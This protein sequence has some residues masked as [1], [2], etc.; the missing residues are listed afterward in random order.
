M[1]HNTS[2]L[3]ACRHVCPSAWTGHSRNSEWVGRAHVAYAMCVAWHAVTRGGAA[4][5]SSKSKQTTLDA[6]QRREE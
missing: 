4:S 2:V 3:T 1:P 6:K 5:A